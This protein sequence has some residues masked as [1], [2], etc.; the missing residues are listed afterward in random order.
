MYDYTNVYSTVGLLY[1]I[2]VMSN[3]SSASSTEKSST[4]VVLP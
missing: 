3:K 2:G 4:S 1:Y